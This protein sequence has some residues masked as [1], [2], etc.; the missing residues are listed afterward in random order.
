[1]ARM[2]RWATRMAVVA[3]VALPIAALAGALFWPDAVAF[4]ALYEMLLL[5]GL[6]A[7]W[8]ASKP[9]PT[10]RR[11]LAAGAA[12]MA[13]VGVFVALQV[14]LAR[15]DSSYATNALIGASLEVVLAQGLL[16]SCAV[17]LL[18]RGFKRTA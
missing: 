18:A 6:A 5:A 13:V 4:A 7:R 9:S 15:H 2:L 14:P 3:A 11:I 16:C 12:A 10:L 1:M 8:A 17:F